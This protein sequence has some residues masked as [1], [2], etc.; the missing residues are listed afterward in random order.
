MQTSPTSQGL[1]ERIVM[2]CKRFREKR[3]MR[4][5]CALRGLVLADKCGKNCYL[6]VKG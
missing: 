4:V 2:K 6:Y 3:G 5:V 1:C